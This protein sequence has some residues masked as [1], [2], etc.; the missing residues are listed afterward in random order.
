MSI[1]NS[2]LETGGVTEA[3]ILVSLHKS[4]KVDAVKL[5]TETVKNASRVVEDCEA[6]TAERIEKAKECQDIYG[7][8]VQILELVKEAEPFP[9]DADEYEDEEPDD[10]DWETG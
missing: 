6:T 8:V 10:R 2:L 4:G 5:L 3:D 1:I 9:E 7:T